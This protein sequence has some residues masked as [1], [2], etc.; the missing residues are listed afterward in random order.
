MDIFKIIVLGIISVLF[1]CMFRKD[2]PQFAVLISII[3]GTVIM[4]LVIVYFSNII[5]Q[6]KYVTV[7]SGIDDDYIAIILKIT[8]ISYICQMAS[9]I[10]SDAG[11]KSIGTRIEIAGKIVIAYTCMPLINAL[12]RTVMEIL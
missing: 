11:E 4:M 12:Y 1:S 5:A 8:G 9:Q 6:I 10:C 2:N 3:S 7:S